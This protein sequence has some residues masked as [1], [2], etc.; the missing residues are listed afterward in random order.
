[1]RLFITVVDSVLTHSAEVWSV[2]LVTAAVA[3]K[4]RGRC[5]LP[6][7][8]MWQQQ[9]GRDRDVGYLRCLLGV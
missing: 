1:M 7:R 8:H 9:R 2:Q 3:T 6:R 5:L 4:N